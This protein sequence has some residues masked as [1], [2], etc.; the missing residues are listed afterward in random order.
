MLDPSQRYQAQLV[1]PGHR[2]SCAEDRGVEADHAI[3]LADRRLMALAE[4][5]EVWVTGRRDNCA[6]S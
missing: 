6:A 3:A 2:W 5:C 4:P 1:A